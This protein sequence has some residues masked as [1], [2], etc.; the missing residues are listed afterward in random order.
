MRYCHFGVSPVNYSDSTTKKT[1]NVIATSQYKQLYRITRTLSRWNP[2]ARK[3][4][5]AH[6][7]AKEIY[8]TVKP[9]LSDHILYKTCFWLF[10]Q[11]V[12][13]C[14]MQVVSD[15][16]SITI[17]VTWMDGRLKMCNCMA[18]TEYFWNHN[19]HAYTHGLILK[20]EIRYEN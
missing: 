16:L 2:H 10:R 18:T 17:F 8:S 1:N 9:A 19:M 13:Y 15:H 11:V 6:K 3:Q 7:R 14:C 20:L 12:A 5:Y 4:T